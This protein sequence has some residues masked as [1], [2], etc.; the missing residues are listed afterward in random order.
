MY[1]FNEINL[2]K[3]HL[4]KWKLFIANGVNFSTSAESY[5]IFASVLHYVARFQLWIDDEGGSSSLDQI[6]LFK[7][8][9]YKI[10]ILE[11]T[12]CKQMI[13]ITK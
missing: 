6:C 9:F 13:I 5:L 8:Y 10:R 1:V 7:N 3:N 12:L 2:M 11:T 4:R